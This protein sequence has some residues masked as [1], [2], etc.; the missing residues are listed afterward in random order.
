MWSRRPAVAKR[1]FEGKPISG[2]LEEII[3]ERKSLVASDD[4]KDIC[5]VDGGR[6]RRVQ[7][8]G[9]QHDYL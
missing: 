1:D 2:Q 5:K 4:E 7:T 8:A 3:G 9:N 6:C